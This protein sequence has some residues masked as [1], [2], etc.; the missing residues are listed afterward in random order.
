LQ[1]SAANFILFL[2]GKELLVPPSFAEPQQHY[3]PPSSPLKSNDYGNK[4]GRETEL[5]VAEVLKKI[6]DIKSIR[7]SEKDSIE[8]SQMIDLCVIF[9]SDNTGLSVPLVNI[10]VK[11][12]Q[13]RLSKFRSEDLRKR[14]LKEGEDSQQKRDEWLL[15]N[16]LVVLNGGDTH[17]VVH[18]STDGTKI[19]LKRRVSDEEILVSFT[20]Q[21]A[22]IDEF[23][24][25]ISRENGVY[26]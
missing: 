7:I 15:K 2:M 3:L 17:Q 10:Q 11:S 22:K 20:R 26:R 16:R 1:L 13:K 24:R 19:K 6:T 8:D 4:R 9:D 12:S 18:N 14:V 25:S 23:N 21:V 5:R